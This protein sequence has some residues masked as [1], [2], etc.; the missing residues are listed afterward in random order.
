MAL[1]RDYE[2][3][4]GTLGA[5]DRKALGIQGYQTGGRVYGYGGGDKIPAMLEGGEFK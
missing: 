5:I 3:K 4:Y 1:L 2:R